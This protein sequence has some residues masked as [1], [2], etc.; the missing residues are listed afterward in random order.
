MLCRCKH[1]LSLCKWPVPRWIASLLEN[2]G[3]LEVAMGRLWPSTAAH[4]FY[5]P[6]G[7]VMT[8][9]LIEESFTETPPWQRVRLLLARWLPSVQ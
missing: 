3:V 5:S 6:D 1:D 9:A 2:D 8:E 4:E 7:H